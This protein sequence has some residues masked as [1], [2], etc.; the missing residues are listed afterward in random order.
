MALKLILKPGERIAVNGAVIVNGDRRSAFV[1]ENRAR[2]LRE[3]DI[4][5]PD[6]ADTP[7]KRVY[8]PIMMMYLDPAAE[9][10]YRRDYE[11]RMTEF[12]QALSTPDAL[13][14][15]AELAAHVANGEHYKALGLCRSLIDFETSRLAH[16]A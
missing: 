4:L 13:R 16:V 5:Q 8:L 7:A 15:C 11:A 14:V 10:A 9:A 6:E 2:V 1:V 12:T 3:R